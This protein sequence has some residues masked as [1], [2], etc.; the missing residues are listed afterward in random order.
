MIVVLDTTDHFY[1]FIKRN[2]EKKLFKLTH[3]RSFK[4]FHERVDLT[5]NILILYN[6]D[7]FSNSKEILQDIDNRKTNLVKVIGYSME[8]H[9]IIE[10]KKYLDDS[11]LIPIEYKYIEN[12]LRLTQ[13][14]FFNVGYL[15]DVPKASQACYI[16]VQLNIE[17]ISEHYIMAS[18][19]H[20]LSKQGFF[21][22]SGPFVKEVFNAKNDFKFSIKEIYKKGKKYCYKLTVPEGHEKA[23]YLRRWV[24]RELGR[25]I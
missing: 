8:K 18:S 6:C 20:L 11:F 5:E 13:K 2:D 9:T 22:F 14:N 19:N 25:E 17:E 21:T 1:S 10:C 16:S 3:I 12:K 7:C 24:I 4:A 23:N 15:Q